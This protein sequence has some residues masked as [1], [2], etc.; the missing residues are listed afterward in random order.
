LAGRLLAKQPGKWHVI[1]LPA[2]NEDG[3]ALWPERF[4]LD[5]LHEIKGLN[6]RDYNALYLGK[7]T[8]DE[9]TFFKREWF[10]GS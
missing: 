10:N 7:P 4:P 3:S 9:G 5:Y 6:L 8:A 2:E 1:N